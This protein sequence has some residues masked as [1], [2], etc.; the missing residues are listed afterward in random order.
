MIRSLPTAVR[1]AKPKEHFQFQFN[2][3][4]FEFAL[5]RQWQ[6]LKTLVFFAILIVHWIGQF[7]AWSYAERSGSMRLLWSILGTPLVH[8]SS[9]IANQ[10]FWAAA[11]ANSVLWAAILTYV[12]ARFALR[13]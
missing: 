4:E 11:T 2:Q 7:V 8:L 6:M 5:T 9:S 10:Y 12:V 1:L 3:L 13:H